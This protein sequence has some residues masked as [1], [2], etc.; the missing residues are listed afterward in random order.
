M[1]PTADDTLGKRLCK[2]QLIRNSGEVQSFSILGMSLI[3]A[4]GGLIIAISFGMEYVEK[5]LDRWFGL[6]SDKRKE[7]VRDETLE[8]LAH[9]KKVM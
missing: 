9:E 4:L 3:L 2:S 8:L 6:G 5:Q 7:W 1:Q